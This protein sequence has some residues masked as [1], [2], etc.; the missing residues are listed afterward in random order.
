[1]PILKSLL[2]MLS[3]LV[4]VYPYRHLKLMQVSSIAI[5]PAS[6]Q[7]SHHTPSSSFIPWDRES[8]GYMFVF[9]VVILERAR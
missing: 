8:S 6:P 4:E 2:H 7:P 9:V 5:H 1:M 3:P